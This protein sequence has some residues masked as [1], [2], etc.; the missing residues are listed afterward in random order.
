MDSLNSVL[1]QYQKNTAVGNAKISEE[2]RMKRYFTTVL[3]KGVKSLEKRIRI[4]PMVD[5]SSPFVEKYFHEI[6]L[7]GQNLKLYDPA[8]DGLRS[9][10]NEVYKGLKE[11]GDPNDSELAK[12]YR[13]KK[14]Y[15]V[16]VIDRDNEQDGPKFWRF[17]HN[18]KKEGIFDKIYPIYRNK[19]DIANPETGRDL[20]LSLTNITHAAAI[21]RKQPDMI[22]A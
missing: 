7:N 9:P 2:E 19:G 21:S 10:L 3:P 20:I 17:K 5:G 4:I 8:Q 13:S 22:K 1:A 18:S 16:K 15:I 11:T 12:N 14:Y 6:A